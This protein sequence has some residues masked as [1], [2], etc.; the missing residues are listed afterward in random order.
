MPKSREKDMTQAQEHRTGQSHHDDF[1]AEV[2]R[3]VDLAPKVTPAQRDLIATNLRPS[4]GGEL[5]A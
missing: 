1:M 4:A 3:I 2:R 5:S